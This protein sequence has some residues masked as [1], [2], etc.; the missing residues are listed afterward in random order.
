MARI[1]VGRSPVGTA[2]GFG[3][4][5]VANN[6]GASVMRVD[7]GTNKVVATIRVGR[8]GAGSTTATV[9]S[10]SP[11]AGASDLGDGPELGDRWCASIRDRTA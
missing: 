11:S 1:P 5:W 2:V 10:P 6:H 8:P 7:P 4:V 3:S 9:R